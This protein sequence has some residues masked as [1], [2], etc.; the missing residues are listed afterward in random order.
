MSGEENGD[1]QPL[2]VTGFLAS[3]YVSTFYFRGTDKDRAKEYQNKKVVKGRD[4][5]STHLTAFSVFAV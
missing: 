3:I 2:V 4:D 5:R 1:L